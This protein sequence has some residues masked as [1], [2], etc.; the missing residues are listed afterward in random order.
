MVVRFRGV[1]YI[2][3]DQFQELRCLGFRDGADTGAEPGESQRS[4]RVT[5]KKTRE[6]MDAP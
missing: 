1:G 5:E 3:G 4:Y 2:L 6:E